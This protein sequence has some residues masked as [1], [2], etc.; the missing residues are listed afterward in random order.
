M[1]FPKQLFIHVR[2]KFTKCN[3]AIADLKLGVGLMMIDISTKQR[4]IKVIQTIH[5][6]SK[7]TYLKLGVELMKIDISARQRKIKVIQ[8]IHATSKDFAIAYLEED[9]KSDK[10]L[11]KFCED[12][13]GCYEDEKKNLIDYYKS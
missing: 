6:T 3:N 7:E 12:V 11:L 4:K 9:N 5:A 8:T 13:I 1:S 2:D 10:V